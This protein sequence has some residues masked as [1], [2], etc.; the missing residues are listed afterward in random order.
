[1]PKPDD[2]NILEDSGWQHQKHSSIPSRG[3]ND[4]ARTIKFATKPTPEQLKAIVAW[5]A[6]DNCPG[7][8]GVTAQLMFGTNS[9]PTQYRFHTTYDSSD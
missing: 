7:W 1:V 8:T 5:L 4:Y 9:E 6:S 2:V 3:I